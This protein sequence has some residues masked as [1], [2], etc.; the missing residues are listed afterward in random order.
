MR[1]QKF[2]WAQTL[3]RLRGVSRPA[4]PVPGLRKHEPRL[5]RVSVLGAPEAQGAKP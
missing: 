2:G 1:P 4:V 5:A 3:A